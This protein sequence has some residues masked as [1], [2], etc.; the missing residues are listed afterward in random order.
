MISLIL[1]I[2]YLAR[3]TVHRWFTRVSSPI[4]RILVVYFLTLSALA[5][6]GSYVI[7]LNVVRDEIIKRGGD[8]VVSSFSMPVDHAVY[9]PSYKEMSDILDA[10]TYI[11]QSLGNVRLEN[12]RNVSAYTYPF[13]RFQ[14]ML[15]LMS[16][17]GRPTLV[18]NPE[19]SHLPE[20]PSFVKIQ[21]TGMREEVLVRNLPEGHPLCRSLMDGLALIVAPDGIPPSMDAG[22]G[23]YTTMVV[24]V[25][26]L[27]SSQSILKVEQFIRHMQ[28]FE[29]L[30]GSVISVSD[31]LR[32]MVAVLDKQMQCRIAFCLGISAIVGILLTALAGM[33]YRQNEYIYTL[34]KSFG[35]HP[36]LLVGA[37]IVENII[38]VGISFV[39]AIATF[40]YSQRVIVVEILKLGNYSLSLEQIASE[41]AIISY[42]LLGCILVSSIPI[43]AAAY[44]QIGRVLK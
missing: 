23:G 5:A 15:P 22:T 43:I 41:I 33:E 11:L 44:R 42:T 28:R 26:H 12:D 3:D 20:G 16:S 37:F 27:T 14:Q 1:T 24:R 40:M 34:M 6:L 38:L 10:D 17:T 9:L 25:R 4:A 35:I 2:L 7:S 39:G 13:N 30:V 31:L 19:K 21:R 29:H 36:L 18:Q 32:R 8:M